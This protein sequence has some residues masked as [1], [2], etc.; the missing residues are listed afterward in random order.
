MRAFVRWRRLGAVAAAATVLSDLP[1]MLAGA[2]TTGTIGASGTTLT[3]SGQ[4]YSFVG[5]NAYELAT[6]W[7]NNAGCGAMLSDGQMAGLFASLPPGGVVRFQAFQETTG[8]NPR[9]GGL[10]WAGLDRVFA[11]AAT[12]RVK[13]IPV[14]GGQGSGCDGGHWEDP[15]WYNGGYTQ[16]YNMPANSDGRGLQPLS[17]KTWVTNVVKRY[18][19]SPALGM[20]EPMGEPEASTCPVAYQPGNCEGHQICPD[21]A[22]AS[23]A[24]SAF[25]TTIGGLIHKLDK[26]HLVEA[27]LLGGGQCGT[28]G[29]DY[30]S[31]ISSPGID[32]ASYHDYYESAPMGGDQWNGI[33]VRIAQARAVNK[34]IIAGELGITAGV[35]EASCESTDQRVTDM[36]AKFSTQFAAG[37]SGEMIWNWSPDGLGPCSFNTTTGDALMGWLATNPI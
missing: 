5:V 36:A 2:A 13:V 18:A 15:A 33:A 17:Y 30:Q 27:G 3:L 16:V 9:T 19:S 29:Q 8:I 32:I 14:L 4:R 35:G 23:A 28:Q 20:W 12:A 1:A 10:N 21:E 7:A 6:D 11:A 31:V 22:A 34:P 37:S 26:S 25:F 24:L